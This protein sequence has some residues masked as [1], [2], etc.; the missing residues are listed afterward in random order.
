MGEIEYI[1][2]SWEIY[3]SGRILQE[4]NTGVNFLRKSGWAL[5]WF[6]E[7]LKF[8]DLLK[9]WDSMNLWWW[10]GW[11]AIIAMNWYL[12]WWVREDIFAYGERGYLNLDRAS[13]PVPY[14]S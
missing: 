2:M 14:T 3:M 11:C 5:P 4:D 7:I 6:D 12:C 8:Y 13:L 9:F 1:Y 10:V